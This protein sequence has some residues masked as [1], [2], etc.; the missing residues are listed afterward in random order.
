MFVPRVKP[1]AP[2]LAS[3][4]KPA[5]PIAGLAVM[6]AQLEECAW[7]DNARAQ[8]ALHC[9]AEH[10]WILWPIAPI[11]GTAESVAHPAPLAKR[12]NVI[13]SITELGATAPARARKVIRKTAVNAAQCVRL[14]RCVRRVHAQR[15]AELRSPIA[16]ALALIRPAILLTVAGAI[17]NVRRA[18]I[19]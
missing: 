15:P 11:A 16:A 4:L 19:A 9:A 8:L 10:A 12:A 6:L 18:P 13:A 5:P 14:L 3:T 2:A 17:D 1:T 7:A